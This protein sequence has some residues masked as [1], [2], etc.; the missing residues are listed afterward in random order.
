[1]LTHHLCPASGAQYDWAGV[2]SDDPEGVGEAHVLEV[3]GH[4]HVEFYVG[5]EGVH[6]FMEV[7]A[8]VFF[9]GVFQVIGSPA[10]FHEEVFHGVQ[11]FRAGEMAGRKEVFAGGPVEAEVGGH[12]ED[13]K[14][15]LVVLF[16]KV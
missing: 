10:G 6:D 4:V 9:E 1:M 2:Y 13:E 7:G 5:V 12:G 14:F 3:F 15:Q 16:Q 8:Q 11:S